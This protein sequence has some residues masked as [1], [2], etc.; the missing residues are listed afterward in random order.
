MVTRLVSFIIIAA[1]IGSLRS[2][3]ALTVEEVTEKLS[4]HYNLHKP[5]CPAD[6]AQK[7]ITRHKDSLAAPA[8]AKFLVAVPNLSGLADRVIG[9]VSSFMLAMLTGRAFQIGP[10]SPLIPLQSVFNT[11]Y[12]NWIRPAD[13]E[14][15]IEPLK[16][17]AKEMNYN[18]TVLSEKRHF[19]VNTLDN[20]KLLNNFLSQNLDGLLGGDAQI[21]YIVINRG[22]SMRIF[23]NKHYSNELEITWRLSQETA[24]GCI[25]HLLF[26]PK[27]EIFLTI[28]DLFSGVMQ[29]QESSKKVVLIGIQIRVGDHIFANDAVQLAGFHAYFDCAR[30]I[31]EFALQEGY[32]EAKWLVVTDSRSLRKEVVAA[33]GDKVITSLH[34]HIEHSAKESS[35]CT[36]NC[37][38]SS[39][40][41]EAAAAEWWMLSFS[42][43]HIISQ[44]SGFGRSASMVGFKGR[45]VYTVPHKMMSKTIAC[46]KN[47][48]TDF[49][50]LPYEWSGV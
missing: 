38:V 9:I 30:Q 46:G 36:H 41:F 34:T 19:A 37:T 2:L 16:Y 8:T 42:T 21:T 26:Q 25:V 40:G 31:E 44:Y 24:F 3:W 39:K 47:S 14:W 10:R 22:L 35:V 12:I 27:P 50:D 43:Y 1:F 45:S 13:P 18:S 28:P 49:Y 5:Q 33:Y 17:K 48:A 15:I 29:V 4:N 6:W 23:T 7:Y 11:K 20:W 32:S